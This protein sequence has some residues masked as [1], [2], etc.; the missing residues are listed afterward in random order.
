[1]L[2]F[3]TTKKQKASIIICDPHGDVADEI[4]ANKYIDHND[5]VYF[6][7]LLFGDGAFGINPF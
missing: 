2:F 5:V 1:M 3:I 7:S 4:F 6:N